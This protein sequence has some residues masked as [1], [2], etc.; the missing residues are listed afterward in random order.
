MTKRKITFFLL[1]VVSALLFTAFNCE[2]K[3]GVVDGNDRVTVDTVYVDRIIKVPE[4]T[5]SFEDSIPD[6]KVVYVADPDLVR[7]YTDLEDENEKLKKYI[8][9]ITIRTYEKTYVSPDSIVSITVRDSVTG[10]LDFQNVDFTVA[11]REVL[12]KERLITKTIEKYPDFSLSLGAG[13]KVP[14]APGGSFSAEGVIGVRIKRGY[15]FQLGVDT[16][17]DVRLTITKDLFIKY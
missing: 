16:N 10:T 8:E 5:G 12:F 1:G 13:V 7:Q 17:T 6:P 15:G 9:A 2:D 14:T 4:I 11:E 3:N